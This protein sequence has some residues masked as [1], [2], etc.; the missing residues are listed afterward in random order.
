MEEEKESKNN[1]TTILFLG[2]VSAV[3]S[4]PLFILLDKYF[5]ILEIWGLRLDHVILFLAIF[6][7][8]YYLLK[9]L[10]LVVYGILITG[11]I[12]LTI[13][14]FS[15]VYTL[16]N[17]Y[18]DYSQLLYDLSEN[19]LRQKFQ[20]NDTFFKKEKELREAI[21]YKDPA[22]RNYSTSIAVKHFQEDA[23]LS[24]NRKW[25]QYFSVFKEIYSQWVYVFDPINEDYY[26]SA[27]NTIKQ[28]N[29]DNLFKGDCDD[30]SIM[31]AAAIKSIG[32]EVRLVRTSLVQD[33]KTI[34]HMYPEV[35]IG[36][37]KDLEMVVYLLKNVFFIEESKGKSIFYFEDSKGFVWL[38]FDYN[39]NYPGGKY[40]SPVR[41]SEI[42]I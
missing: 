20:T 21:D 5:P 17:L 25:V 32:G 31:M 39:D 4:M 35:K 33:G 42:I 27:S 34:G 2:V 14:N 7:A 37:Q 13:T 12:V 38:N 19:S 9:K 11:L 41:E 22:V 10:R 3:L 30:Y 15:N 28:L 6:F 36:D 8:T 24:K 16:E 40:M 26:S 1:G 18:H 29:D 23:H